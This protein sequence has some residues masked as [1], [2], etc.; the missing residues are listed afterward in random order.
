[1]EAS[2]AAQTLPS[3]SSAEAPP[4][5]PTAPLQGVPRA[6]EQELRCPDPVLTRAAAATAK[7]GLSPPAHRGTSGQT[8]STHTRTLGRAALTATAT[9]TTGT[10]QALQKATSPVS[11]LTRNLQ[12]GLSHRD[13]NEISSGGGERP[14]EPLFKGCGVSFWGYKVLE[15]ETHT[16]TH[17]DTHTHTDTQTL[18]IHTHTH[19]QTLT[20]TPTHTL[21]YT[22]SDTDTLRYT[23]IQ[24]HLCTHR[25]T[26]THRDTQTY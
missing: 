19:S 1:M 3:K 7:G 12:A 23:D 17:R 26:Q 5:G 2:P 8:R 15:S 24:R 18:Q 14:R 11:P 10:R 16:L 22:H 21:R 25:C 13:Q 6:H 20:Q 4:R 9:D